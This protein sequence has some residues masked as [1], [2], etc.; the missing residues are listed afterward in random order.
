[1]EMMGDIF[2]VS[3][4]MMLLQIVMVDILL[5]G[6]NAIVIAMAAEKLPH[7]LQKTA[8][9]LGTGGA[10]VIRF[11]MAFAVVWLLHIPYLRIVGGGSADCH[12][13]PSSAAEE[14][15]RARKDQGGKRAS[16]GG[17]GHYHGG[18]HDESR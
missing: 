13:H 17:G 18:R 5:G 9:I 11:L 6:D 2:S 15:G 14:T 3:F 16:A 10:I 8:I 7:R 12:R 1:M 4:F